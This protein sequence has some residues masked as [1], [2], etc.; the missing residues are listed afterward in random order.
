M[1]ETVFTIHSLDFFAPFV[2]RQKVL[3]NYF[4][5]KNNEIIVD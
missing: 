2:S 3:K 4:N 5:E 1:T